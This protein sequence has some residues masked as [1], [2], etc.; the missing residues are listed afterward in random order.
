MSSSQDASSSSSEVVDAAAAASA[1]VDRRRAIQSIMADKSLTDL[2]QR[3]RVQRLMD[4]S[5]SNSSA[6]E[7]RPPSS[8]ATASPF[9]GVCPIASPS[10]SSAATTAA[11]TTTSMTMAAHTATSGVNNNNDNDNH[12]GGDAPP[13][14]HYERKCDIIAPC[15]LRPYGCRICHD[16]MSPSCG[17]MDR[18]AISVIVC[19]GCKRKQ[20]S[21]T[22]ECESCHTSFAEYHCAE[23]NLWMSMDKEPFHCEQCGICRVGGRKNYRHC[24]TCC[25]CVSASVYDTH[26]CEYAVF[27]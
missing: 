17:T 9:F 23:C 13:C 21:K 18:F 19:R 3:L 8:T 15:C 1:A 11:A 14:V 4:G 22:N 25:M 5:S 16:E 27:A 26:A 6:A 12:H 7:A 2:E 20:C 10:S 24:D